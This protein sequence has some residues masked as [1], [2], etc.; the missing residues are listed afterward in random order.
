MTICTK[1]G[2][3][4]EGGPTCPRCGAQLSA[5]RSAKALA[6]ASGIIGAGCALAAAVDLIVDYAQ[7]GEFGWSRIGLASSI[8]GWLLIGFPMLTYRRPALFLGVMGASILAY[9]WTL[10]L[11]TGA[12]GWFLA[13]A[14]PMALVVMASGALS[15]LLCV[16]A[17]RRGPNVAGFILLGC[18]MACLGIEG[19]LALRDG[20]AWS[21]GWSGIVAV[22]NLPLAFLLFGLQHRLRGRDS[23][24]RRSQPSV[25]NSS[26]R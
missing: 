11:L 12:T 1:C 5:D 10:D 7:N 24:D 23:E 4:A 20:A 3:E 16:R 25:A 17:R 15:A 9:L 22:V 13:L 18:T 6:L 21:F 2:A 14:L 26:S 8:V 19:I